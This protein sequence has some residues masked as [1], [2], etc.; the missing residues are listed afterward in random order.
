[1]NL[2][3]AVSLIAGLLLL[4]A[5]R[6]L[7]WLFVGLLAFAVSVGFLGRFFPN[8]EPN[9]LLLVSVVLGAL[10]AVAAVALAKAAVWVGGFL[11]GGY[12]GMIV[13]EMLFPAS[14]ALPWVALV[15]GGILGILLARFLFESILIVGSS[16]AGAALLVQTLGAK[17]VPGLLLLILLAVI[18]VVV[19]GRFLRRKS[20]SS[21]ATSLPPEE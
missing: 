5:G 21:P 19:Q 11:G 12:V 16:A 8:L 9:T 6:K 13:W 17:E 7:I 18:G 10:G 14:A 4:L 2:L 15:L 1:M 20:K 3:T